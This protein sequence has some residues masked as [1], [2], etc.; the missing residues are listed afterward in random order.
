VDALKDI[1]DFKIICEDRDQGDKMP[2]PNEPIGRWYEYGSAYILRVPP[3]IKGARMILEALRQES[4]DVLY[5]NSFC[6]R[7][8]S[9]L[10]L[11]CRRVGILPKKPVVLAPRGEFSHGALGIKPK[12]K[13]A[14]I[15]L[16]KMAHLL[17]GV[18]WQA[19]SEAEARDI[20][21]VLGNVNIR[22]AGAIAGGLFP[23]REES[24]Q[25]NSILAVPDMCHCGRPMKSS[26]KNRVKVPGE[27]RVVSLGRVCLMKNIEYAIQIF[28]QVQGRVWY[29]VYGPLEDTMYV[30]KCEQQRANLPDQVTFR[31][32]GS[33]P[34]G[35]VSE[36]LES[37][38]VFLLP[39]LGE[40]FG[41][42]I[43][44]AMRA[45]CVPLI[46]D[47]TPWRDLVASNAGWDLP[48]SC[49]EAFTSALHTALSWS[50]DEFQIL[51]NNA[52]TYVDNHALTRDAVR[53][54]TML[55]EAAAGTV[56]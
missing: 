40:S 24:N 29:D 30:V 48:L 18:L 28:K 50:D 15:A 46:S 9:I 45:G 43:A 17:D 38:H 49:P 6:A 1:Y 47:R 23:A 44:E 26:S 42:V 14:Y 37:Y 20:R 54:N 7:R 41:H 21:R 3:G 33:I 22:K 27:L 8:F 56:S 13:R 19:S 16:A 11:V 34:H 5:I 25:G 36:M 53:E 10:P 51:S 55:F 2:F 39:S 35:A 52:I 12:R 32:M 31:F 4:Y